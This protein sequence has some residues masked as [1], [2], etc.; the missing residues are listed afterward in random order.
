MRSSLLVLFKLKKQFILYS[1]GAI[2]YFVPTF[3]FASPH[4]NDRPFTIALLPDTQYYKK[5]SGTSRLHIFESQTRWIADNMIGENIILTI[6][7][8]DIVDISTDSL[9]LSALKSLNFIDGLM[10]FILT[11]GNHDI[12][13]LKNKETSTYEKSYQLFEK[14]FTEEKFK[15]L[16]W[17]GGTFEKGTIKNSFY[18]FNLGGVDY[19]ILTL[20]YGPRDK[21]LDWANKIIKNFP[22]KKT[23]IV[24]HA[25]MAKGP[26]RLAPG[27]K[28]SPKIKGVPFEAKEYKYSEREGWANG[29]NVIWEKLVKNHPNIEFVFSG[30]S[31]GPGKLISKGVHGNPV[32]QVGAN[33][34]WEE[35]GGNG[36]LRLMKF[37]P[38]KKQ[39][40]VK[41]YSPLLDHFRTDFENNF[42]IDLEKGNFSPIN[43]SLK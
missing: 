15:K 7:L 42:Q 8:G 16:P 25:Y 36:Y 35:N 38:Q 21:V 11:A 37:Y 4:A 20:E 33:Y 3:A 27:A 28:H 39:V 12:L 41:T 26:V 18:F 40:T 1:F 13:E 34:Q 30:H 29:G 19:L 10:P 2:L 22:T 24:T 31:G 23:I 14:H 43:S 5:Y 9:W 6:H 32:F 17:Y